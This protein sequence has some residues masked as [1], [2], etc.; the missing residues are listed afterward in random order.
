M[1]QAVL[2]MGI[3]EHTT[4]NDTLARKKFR[5][6][7]ALSTQIKDEHLKAY[8]LAF[9][10]LT[11][12]NV[13]QLDS[14]EACYTN[15]Y[16]I[17]KDSLNSDHLSF[18]YLALAKL[19][20]SKNNPT[21]QLSYLKR[22]W[23]IRKR[24][25]DMRLLTNAGKELV[26][27]Y[28]ERSEYKKS[29]SILDQIQ[30]AMGKDTVDNEEIIR[31][32]KERAIIYA[33]LGNYRASLLLFDKVKKFYERNASAI[34]LVNLFTDMGNAL[35]YSSSNYETSLKYFF[36]AIALAEA[37]QFYREST[38]LY[39]RVAWVYYLMEQNKLAEE[40]SLKALKLAEEKYSYE[41]ATASNVLGLLAIRKQNYKE[42]FNYLN[43]SLLI[44]EKNNFR[45]DATSSLLNLGILFEKTGDLIKA[46]EY[47]LKSLAMARDLGNPVNISYAYQTL[48]QLYT[49]MKQFGKALVYLD[50]AEALSKKIK[51]QDI[52]KDVYQNKRDLYRAQ[53]KLTDALRYS[54]LYEALHD[55]L[56][57]QNL[58]NRISSMQ[59]DFEIDQKDNQIKILNQQQ[60]IQQNRLAHQQAEIRQQRTI[61]LVGVII[62]LLISIASLIIF[63]FYRKVKQLNRAISEQNEEITAQSEELIE[64]NEILGKLNRE[65]SEQK[66]EIQ[67]Q[68]EELV[69]SHQAIGRINE[70]LEEKIKERTIELKEAYHEL[71]TFFYRSSHDFRRPLTTFMGLHEVA[72]IMLHDKVAL[73]LFEKVNDTARSL[74]KMLNKLQT[75]NLASSEELVKTEIHFKTLIE[76]EL[77][78]FRDELNK[79]KIKVTIDLS[80]HLPFHSY[81]ALVKVMIQNLLENSI[82]FCGIT[83]P[84]IKIRVVGQPEAAQIIISD[85]GQG[86]HPAYLPRVWEMYYRANEGSTGNGLGLYIVKKIV[87]RLR[88]Q[89]VIESGLGGGTTITITL[90]NNNN[91]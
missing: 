74:D 17:L 60:Q 86:I 19:H 51:A 30:S 42:A 14:A 65:I 21:L 80:L 28:T 52:L 35:S 43:Q 55:S 57:N 40:F 36:K 46:E 33:D 81:S 54:L 41:E 4:G 22:S 44:R 69:E 90:P 48:G 7:M 12:Q 88:G 6:C 87:N 77:A 79:K 73:D 82:A 16:K 76:A 13:D 10:G 56:F 78:R 85:N 2:G 71:D 49:K 31:V 15:A 26:V 75:V 37:K 50:Q 61:I 53:S 68:S 5:L 8:A 3:I 70:G 62:L 45:D 63:R 91:L 1:A 32:Y 89:A 59:Y 83:D 29:I 58:S 38:L 24:M 47:D 27:Y 34:E 64:A 23:E 18:L 84:E 66:E 20:E 25:N 11:Y 67:A 9:I 72:K 39:A